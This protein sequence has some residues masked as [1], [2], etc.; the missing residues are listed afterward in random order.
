MSRSR[1]CSRRAFLGASVAAVA[2]ASA[3]TAG[4]AVPIGAGQGMKAKASTRVA[5]TAG[6]DRVENIFRALTP[7]RDQLIRSIGEKRIIIKPNN[8]MIESQ[9]SATHADC[10]VGILEFLRSI[11]K[12]NVII[13]ESSAS[14]PTMD[15][16]E[17]F[18]YLGLSEK[19]RAPLV[20]LDR[21][22][23]EPV[24]IFDQSDFR[25]KPVRMSR[26][27]LDRESNFI[28]SAAKFKT[29][30]RVVA[31]LSL[32]NIVF[33][34]PVKDPGFAWG[35]ARQTGTR[36]DKHIPHGSGVR[37][38]NYNL[39]ALAPRLQPSLAVIDGF[40]GMEGDGPLNGTPVEH[41]V[42]VAGLDWLAADRVAVEL[43]GI[44]FSTI[45]YLNYCAEAGMGQADLSRIEI[46]GEKI[47]NHVRKYR[48][49]Q[50]IEKQLVWMKPVES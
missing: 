21:Q 23:V 33:G 10:L 41:G 36:T 1:I 19:Y 5:L 3:S 37:A 14:G 32:K 11:G 39:F 12:T 29:H 43:M 16:F 50:N 46:V 4:R 40:V 49:N 2:A 45:G 48:L 24:Y 30:D 15:G 28:I 26:M 17:N 9:L 47:E 27:L 7:F 34:A 6:P 18:N 8:V 25:P 31:T 13:A 44:D 20:D 22:D 42:A 38:T 35:P